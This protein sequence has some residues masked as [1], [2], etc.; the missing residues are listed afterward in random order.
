MLEDVLAVILIP[1][2]LGII[3]RIGRTHRHI[4]RAFLRAA[5]VRD[6]QL[7]LS[8]DFY[9]IRPSVLVHL[10]NFINRHPLDSRPAVETAS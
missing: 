4:Q 9:V 1:I 3:H 2:L 8:D 5:L 6:D 10:I 7:I